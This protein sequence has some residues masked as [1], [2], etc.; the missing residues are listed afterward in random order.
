MPR[1]DQGQLTMRSL[2]LTNN[3]NIDFV[4]RYIQQAEKIIKDIPEMKSRLSIVQSPGESNALNLL[5]PWE[6]RSRSTK[7]IAESIRLKLY[8]I[9][10][11]IVT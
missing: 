5:I 7:E 10:D 6:D 8:D 9:V 4:D 11:L 3:A 1:E 2:P